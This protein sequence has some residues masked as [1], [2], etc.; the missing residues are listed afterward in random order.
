MVGEGR[1]RYE[2]EVARW[3]ESGWKGERGWEGGKRREEEEVKRRKE[4]VER[5][6]EEGRGS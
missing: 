1:G 3:R 6:E 5:E 2:R 4:E